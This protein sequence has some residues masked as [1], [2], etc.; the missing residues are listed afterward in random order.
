MIGEALTRRGVV[1]LLAGAFATGGRLPSAAESIV[2]QDQSQRPMAGH[3]NPAWEIW[4]RRHDE[5]RA[6]FAF[7][8]GGVEPHIATMHSWSQTTKMRV[9]LRR[10]YEKLSWF[11]RLRKKLGLV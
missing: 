9:Q 3:P 10:D 5:Y 7:R 1:G 4:Q 6:R 8:L 2:Q 11:E